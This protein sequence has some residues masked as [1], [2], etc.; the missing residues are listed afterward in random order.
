MARF[1]EK[2]KF[3]GYEMAGILQ[4]IS[5]NRE[6]RKITKDDIKHAV[7]AAYLSIYPGKTMYTTSP[8][9]APMGHTSNG[10]LYCVKG[11]ENG[12]ASVVWCVRWHSAVDSPT[13]ARI[14]IAGERDTLG[15]SIVNMGSNAVPSKIYPDL[16]IQK[17]ETKI[18]VEISFHYSNFS[19]GRD[20]GNVPVKTAF[21]FFVLNLP[22]S[23]SIYFNTVVIFTPKPGLFSDAAP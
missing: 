3:V 14:S 17:G 9:R 1:R 12:K 6:N 16:R 19:D 5:Q 10:H 7:A 22:K 15:R 11:L 2:L 8:N 13:P 21:G 20:K 18:L 23:D 4:N